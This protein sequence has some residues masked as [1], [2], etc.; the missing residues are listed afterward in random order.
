MRGLLLIASLF[1]APA[2]AQDVGSA[3]YVAADVDAKRFPDADTK[4]PALAGGDEVTVVYVEGDLVRVMSGK[5][6]GWVPATALTATDPTPSEA[7]TIGGSGGVPREF[8]MEALQELLD[9]TKTP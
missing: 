3:M 7:I 9:R 8:S 6:F 4:G 5:D 1:A 2:F